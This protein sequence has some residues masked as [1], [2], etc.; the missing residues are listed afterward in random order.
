MD[1]SAFDAAIDDKIDLVAGYQQLS[2]AVS[3][4]SSE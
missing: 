4:I 2:P 1:A 3:Y